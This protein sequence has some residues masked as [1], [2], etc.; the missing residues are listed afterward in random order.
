M[1]SPSPA[2]TFPD[3][4]AAAL[5]EDAARPLVTFYDDATGERV[6]LS[7]TTYANWV[8]KTASLL[9]DELDVERG[10]RVLLDLPTHWLTAVWLGALWSLGASATDDLADAEAADAVVCGPAGVGRWAGLAPTRPVVAMSLRPLGARFDEPLPAG[11]VDYGAVVLG[12]P[13]AFVAVDPPVSGDQAW[14]D[15]A[16]TVSQAD[17]AGLRLGVEVAPGERLL[18]D[19]P[20]ASRPGLAALLVPLRG[21][22]GTVWVRHPEPASWE[23]RRAV[24]RAGAVL[25]SDGQPP[26]S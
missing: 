23:H 9:H 8:A 3:L 17:L 4:L 7:V 10:A 24:E 2:T 25:R 13:D 14:R 16:G 11:I 26:R 15:R 21:G 18:T 5:R 1:P 22:G 6:E 20:P 19:V 12:Q